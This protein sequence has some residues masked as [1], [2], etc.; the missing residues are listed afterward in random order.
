MSGTRLLKWGTGLCI[1]V[2]ACCLA[3]ASAKLACSPRGEKTNKQTKKTPLVPWPYPPSRIGKPTSVYLQGHCKD[4]EN[5]I[6][7][8]RP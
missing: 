1:S 8:S 2:T 6:D 3:A 4:I 5:W 7:P